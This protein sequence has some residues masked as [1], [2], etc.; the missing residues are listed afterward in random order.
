MPCDTI[1]ENKV[2]LTNA[3]PEILRE[4]LASLGVTNYTF[5]AGVVT[6][7]QRLT[8]NEIN[9]AYSKTVLQT[10]AKR[11]GWSVKEEAN[12]KFTLAKASMGARL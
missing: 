12:R 1:R 11:F 6:T 9:R 8:A 5:A 7:R 3:N 4:A 10:Q 2:Q